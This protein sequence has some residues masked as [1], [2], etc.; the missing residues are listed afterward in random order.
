MLVIE[1]VGKTYANV[2]GPISS[3]P[4][5]SLLTTLMKRLCSLTASWSCVRGQDVCVKKLKRRSRGH[6]I[7]S[8]QL[9]ITSSVECWR[10]DRSLDLTAAASGPEVKVSAG[11]ALWW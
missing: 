6:A 10:L 3:Q 1:H 4:L 9:L 7:V 5:S 2:F 11:Q 8:R